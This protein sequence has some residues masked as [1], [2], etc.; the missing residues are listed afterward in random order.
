MSAAKKKPRASTRVQRFPRS[1]PARPEAGV[2]SLV[3]SVARSSLP[4]SSVQKHRRALRL[5]LSLFSSGLSPGV[6]CGPIRNTLDLSATTGSPRMRLRLLE[7]L[8]RLVGWRFGSQGDRD[9]R[10]RDSRAAGTEASGR[11]RRNV[12][13]NQ[14]DDRAVVGVAGSASRGSASRGSASTGSASTPRSQSPPPLQPPAGL[15]RRDMPSP[16]IAPRTSPVSGVRPASEA[17]PPLPRNYAPGQGGGVGRAR[18][19]EAP[20]GAAPLD[21]ATSPPGQAAAA[22]SPGRAAQAPRQPW[23]QVVG[24]PPAARRLAGAARGGRGPQRRGHQEGAGQDG[25]DP[26]ERHPRTA[27]VR[28]AAPGRLPVHRRRAAELRTA[29][30]DPVAPVGRRARRRRRRR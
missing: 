14:H 8:G 2:F 3:E 5:A 27:A 19:R 25:H 11:H 26:G 28:H 6:T 10:S 9:G 7:R 17:M 20:F 21:T 15:P 22:A 4:P 30:V 1:P 23:Y 12:A 13:G 29:R 18:I 16:R 24:G